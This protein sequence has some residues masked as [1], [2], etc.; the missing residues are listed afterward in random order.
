MECGELWGRNAAKRVGLKFNYKAEVLIALHARCCQITGEI[1][2]LIKTGFADG[3][4]A[5]WRSLHEVTVIGLFISDHSE[6]LAKRYHLHQDIETFDQ[7][8][9]SLARFPELKND[10]EFQA[11]FSELTESKSKLIKKFGNEFS[12][13]YG[14]AAKALNNKRPTFRDIEASVDMAFLRPYYKFASMNVHASAK[15]AFY[16]VGLIDGDANSPILLAG[17]SNVGFEEP[18][19]LASISL[20]QFTIA[21]LAIKPDMD[22]LVY[23]KVV[24]YLQKETEKKFNKC[25]IKLSKFIDEYL[26]G[27]DESQSNLSS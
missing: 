21:I 20:T 26:G 1:L 23:M 3:A 17:R 15:G 5:R 14:W 25:A 13:D 7:A 16:R 12:G 6:E 10:E 18:A 11:R 27:V 19:N 22:Q 9:G 2:A 8:E 24:E 4:Y